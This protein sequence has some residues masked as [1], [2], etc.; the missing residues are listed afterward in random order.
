M[1]QT[2]ACIL[3]TVLLLC[4]LSGCQGEELSG[5][6]H[7]AVLYYGSDRSW[8]DAYSH[9]SQALLS[10][11]TVTAIDVSQSFSLDQVDVL[12]PDPSIRTAPQAEQIR[13][14]IISKVIL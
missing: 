6:V 3:C 14:D 4:G 9:L 2:M 11:L 8:E 1:K 5:D 7:A 10:N 12:Y 13:D